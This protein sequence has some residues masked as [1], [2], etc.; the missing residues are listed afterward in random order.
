MQE[1][2][3]RKVV[4]WN[5]LDGWDWLWIALSVLA[6]LFTV[7]LSYST[8]IQDWF[9]ANGWEWIT[10]L[11]FATT[12][13]IVWFFI[14]HDTLTTTL[15]LVGTGFANIIVIGFGFIVLA[16]STGFGE[17]I[18][19]EAKHFFANAGTFGGWWFL[20]GIIAIFTAV[21][22]AIRRK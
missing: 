14:G 17:M 3:L 2:S 19:K 13:W 12:F 21:I 9:I 5:N 1:E 4:N 15:A 11:S 18:A 10:T 7:I 22:Y 16:F 20:I 8:G 6:G